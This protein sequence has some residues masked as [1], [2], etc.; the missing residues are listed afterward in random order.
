MEGL[1][2]DRPE[3]SMLLV[4][5]SQITNHLV[6]VDRGLNDTLR[7]SLTQLASPQAIAVADRSVSWPRLSLVLNATRFRMSDDDLTEALRER[8]GWR[9][10]ESKV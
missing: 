6:F 5:L 8:T 9:E 7:S 1:N 3:L 4:I 10:E 2:T